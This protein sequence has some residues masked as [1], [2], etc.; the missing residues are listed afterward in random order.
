MQR[1]ILL[2]Y[3]VIEHIAVEHAAH[4]G[5]TCATICATSA[6]HKLLRSKKYLG[7]GDSVEPQLCVLVVCMCMFLLLLVLVLFVVYCL[8]L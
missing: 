1:V 7:G 2:Q 5:C 8:C 6:I 3:C 4:T